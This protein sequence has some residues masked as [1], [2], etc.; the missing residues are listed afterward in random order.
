MTIMRIIDSPL[1]WAIAG[2]LIGLLL[3]VTTASVWLLAA[4]FGLF[5]AYLRMHGPSEE[6]TEGWLYAAGPVFM[7]SW[8]L[9]FILKDVV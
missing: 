1:P 6:R 7:V 3:G 4:G 9:G 8:V 2:L 5:V